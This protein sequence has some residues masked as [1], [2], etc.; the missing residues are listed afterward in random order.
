MN[1]LQIIAVEDKRKKR[2]SKAI[3]GKRIILKDLMED[4]ELLKIELNVIKHEYDIRIGS[5]LLKDNQ[6]DLEILQIKNLKKCMDEG[7]SYK[8]ALKHEEDAFYNEILRLQQEQDRIDEEKKEYADMNIFSKEIT[9]DVKNLWKKLIRKFHPDL[10]LDIK[11]KLQR[12]EIVKKINKAY[13]ENDFET[14]SQYEHYAN[15]ENK[16]ETSVEMLEKVLVDIENMIIRLKNSFQDLK[17]SQWFSW[18]KKYDTAKRSSIDIFAD[19][20]KTLLDDIVKKISILNKLKS[21]ISQ[22]QTP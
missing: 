15:I 12:E 17:K 2:L 8:E 18:R 9:Q 20:E 6:L 1:S 7:M 13:S 16:N 10:V 5:L 19:L 21:E 11:E 4:V 3:D 22:Y 14:L